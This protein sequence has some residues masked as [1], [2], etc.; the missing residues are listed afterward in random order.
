MYSFD[1]TMKTLTWVQMFDMSEGNLAY[2]AQRIKH[3]GIAP[4]IMAAANDCPVYPNA[5]GSVSS[6]TRMAIASGIGV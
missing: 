3:T 5:A 6:R 1:P 2:G 4:E